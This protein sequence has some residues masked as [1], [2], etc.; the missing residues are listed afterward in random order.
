MIFLALF[1]PV[2]IGILA[3]VE[4]TRIEVLSHAVSKLNVRQARAGSEKDEAGS[5]SMDIN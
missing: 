5:I 4:S 2:L 1:H 3:A